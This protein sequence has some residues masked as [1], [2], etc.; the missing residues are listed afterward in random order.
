MGLFTKDQKI[1]VNTTASKEEKKEAFKK[2]YKITLEANPKRI[3]NIAV[4][5]ESIFVHNTL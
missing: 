2:G 4:Q 3:H 5:D 1:F